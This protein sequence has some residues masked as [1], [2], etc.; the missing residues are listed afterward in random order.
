MKRAFICTGTVLGLGLIGM[1]SPLGREWI[2]GL[3]LFSVA[4]A[5]L[6]VIALVWL[7]VENGVY[8]S[9]VW[10]RSQAPNWN[11]AGRER[12]QEIA[13]GLQVRHLWP[14]WIHKASTPVPSANGD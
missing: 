5:A 9:I 3:V 1:A 4:Y 6:F 7:V 12:M 8:A 14:K 10:L 11:R 13:H 2:A